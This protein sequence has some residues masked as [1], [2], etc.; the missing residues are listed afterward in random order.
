M[1]HMSHFYD[2]FA[3]FCKLASSNL[4]LLHYYTAEKQWYRFEMIWGRVEIVIFGWTVPLKKIIISNI[5]E[6]GPV[7]LILSDLI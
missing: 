4:H 3:S 6:L 5:S 7:Y 1:K 2:A